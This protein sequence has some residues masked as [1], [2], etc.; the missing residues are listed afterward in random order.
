MLKKGNYTFCM[1]C[2]LLRMVF[3]RSISFDPI[4]HTMSHTREK[5]NRMIEPYF[6]NYLFFFFFEQLF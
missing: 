4:S 5:K 2:E 3:V 6:R 1:Q